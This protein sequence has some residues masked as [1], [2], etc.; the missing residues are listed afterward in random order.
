MEGVQ[1]TEGPLCRAHQLVV[2]LRRLV[3]RLA[4]RLSPGPTGHRPGARLQPE[5]EWLRGHMWALG[6]R[7]ALGHNLIPGH[8]LGRQCSPSLIRGHNLIPGHRLA[9]NHNLISGHSLVR[10]SSPS[11]IL[12]HNLILGPSLARVR[13]GLNR[14]GGGV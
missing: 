14:P 7:L 5:S 6:P 2:R 1:G 9:R 8:S 3:R 12:G 13:L 10:Q 11:L 4:V